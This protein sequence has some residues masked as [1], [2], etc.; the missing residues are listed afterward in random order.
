[1]VDL[2]IDPATGKP[3]EPT[4]QTNEPKVNPE[5]GK[6]EIDPVEFAKLTTKLDVFERANLGTPQ[7]V[8]PNPQPTQ[9]G[10]T[11]AERVSEIDKELDKIDDAIDEA[12][13][14]QR[15][16]KELNRKRDAL[17]SKRITLQIEH[18]QINPLRNFGIEVMTQ[19]TSE[20]SK[21]KMPHI[22]LVRDDF[23]NI[24]RGLDQ[25]SVV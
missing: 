14:N 11:L 5:T 13:Q 20:L 22:D 7:P 6:L 19:H 16:V 1:M 25:K 3:K 9:Q 24:L 17:T 15:S 18:E 2:T 4:A 23:D 12:I 8:Q 10:P 21:G